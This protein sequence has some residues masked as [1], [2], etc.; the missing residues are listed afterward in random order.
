MHFHLVNT[1]SI[2]LKEAKLVL[3]FY[4]KV[5][6]SQVRVWGERTIKKKTNL[7]QTQTK[8]TNQKN[9]NKNSTTK[10]NNN[11][12]NKIKNPTNNTING[13]EH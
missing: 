10:P 3:Y 11:K 8:P 9:L 5:T 2:T 12:N 7:K 6:A 4:T 1:G 13:K